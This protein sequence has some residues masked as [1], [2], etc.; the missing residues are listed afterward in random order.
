MCFVL[1]Y[2]TKDDINWN[3]LNFDADNDSLIIEINRK[4]KLP[5]Q[6]TLHVTDIRVT[7]VGFHNDAKTYAII[8]DVFGCPYEG[9]SFVYLSLIC[10]S[11]NSVQ[12]Y[13]HKTIATRLF[14]CCLEKT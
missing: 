3:R 2:K 7:V 4:Y 1:E 13:A 14:I 5:D 11:I 9:K 12:G 10:I 6:E 8:L